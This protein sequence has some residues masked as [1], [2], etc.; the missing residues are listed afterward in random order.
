MN[1]N[2]PTPHK[3]PPIRPGGPAP[4]GGVNPSAPA[5]IRPAPP[6]PPPKPEK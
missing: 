3:V 2:I 1:K 4:I 5:N 6:P